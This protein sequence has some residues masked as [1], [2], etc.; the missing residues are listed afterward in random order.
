MFDALIAT[1]G[2]AAGAVT[3]VAAEFAFANSRP[4]IIK[5]MTAAMFAAPAAVPSYHL[6]LGL[7]AL[8]TPSD[9]WRQVFAIS[10]AVAVGSTASTRLMRFD[11]ETQGS[12]SVP[13]S[14]PEPTNPG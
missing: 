13:A 6:L 7:T 3:L 12:G 4:T 11:L 9:A 10:G 14:G 1:V 8:G 2:L 5:N